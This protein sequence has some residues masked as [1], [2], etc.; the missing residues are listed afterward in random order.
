MSDTMARYRRAVDDFDALV[1][2][3]G[4]DDWDRPSMCTEWTVRDVLGHVVW[5]QRLTR[6]WATGHDYTGTGGAPGAP[7]PGR[8]ELAGADPSAAWREARAACDAALTPE[9][10]S[11]RVVSSAFGEIAV[12]RFVTVLVADFLAHTFD[13]GHALGRDVRLAPELVPG[14][15]E[16][17]RKQAFRAPGGIGPELTPPEDADEQTRLLAFLGRRAW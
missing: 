10:L 9:G 7:H 12:E 16:W 5:G 3:L 17:A 14:V 13:I 6:G 4:G 15:F 1:S 8:D 2:T 11:R